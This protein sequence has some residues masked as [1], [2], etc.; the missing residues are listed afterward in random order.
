MDIY[1][2]IIRPIVTEKSNLLAAEAHQFTF[3]VHMKANKIEIKSAIETLFDVDVLNVNTLVL[4]LKRGTRGRKTY[5]RVPA[6]K[7]A[8]VTLPSDQTIALFNV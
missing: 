3:E 7:K 6:I 1:S 4:P 5:Q 2:V 8:I